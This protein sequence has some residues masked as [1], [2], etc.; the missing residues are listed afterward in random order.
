MS[1]DIYC[2]SVPRCSVLV[3]NLLAAVSVCFE[4][5]VSSEVVCTGTVESCVMEEETGQALEEVSGK[6]AHVK[7]T[8]KSHQ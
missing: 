7:G 1:N 3:F 4:I 5:L 8:W 2:V 6:Q